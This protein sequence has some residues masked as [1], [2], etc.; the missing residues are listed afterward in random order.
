[1][2]IPKTF[3]S[4]VHGIVLLA[5]VLPSLAYAPG[6]SALDTPAIFGDHMVLQAEAVVPI[7]GTAEADSP[8]T[9]RWRGKTYDTISDIDG[10]WR[11]ELDPQP[12]GGPYELDITSGNQG[13]DFEDVM[14]GQVW[15]CGGQSNMEWPVR[16]SNDPARELSGAH[17]PMIRLFKVPRASL[18]DL[19]GELQGRWELCRPET[20]AD[21]S[22][23]GYF[24]GREIQE[25]LDQPVGLI[26]NAWGG[27]SAEA[28][29]SRQTLQDDPD[30]DYVIKSL[31]AAQAAFDQWSA[32]VR[33]WEDAGSEG[34][35]PR[36]PSNSRMHTWAGLLHDRML[37]PL[38]PYRLRGVIWYQGEQNRNE[39]YRYRKLFPAMIGEWRR[40]FENERLPFLFVQL[41]NT[42]PPVDSPAE[43]A[44]A[45]LRE[46]QDL[47]QQVPH[48]A[49]VTAIDVGDTVGGDIH[50]S[51]KQ[52]VGHR[53]ARAALA[54]VYG[55]EVAYRGPRY[56]SMQIEDEAV[57][58]M[59][60]DAPGGLRTAD[61]KPPRGFALAQDDGPF[62]WAD[63]TIEGQ[64]V[65]LR[66]PGIT[67]PTAV[68]Y[69]WADNPTATLQ[70]AAG[71]P[72]LPFRTDDRPGLTQPQ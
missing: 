51:D 18:L 9:L 47:T 70:N 31:P 61:A 4:A 44:W 2:S 35:R 40:L 72:A 16:K 38:A 6:A 34:S 10:R 19:P 54:T 13:M 55:R 5:V 26:A 50:P 20:A 59:F 30:L 17:R 33:A 12:A 24:F 62:I 71:L 23:V 48:T 53:L 64:S 39:A 21:F 36:P 63:A 27:S 22:G 60:G 49:M 42:R 3:D 45:E 52:S 1:M 25:T 41:A 32:E 67:H 66:A 46:V 56:R 11:I 68:R 15:L 65:L 43:S 14:L 29:M 58:V 69:L 37:Q 8:V 57:R 7:W 28:W